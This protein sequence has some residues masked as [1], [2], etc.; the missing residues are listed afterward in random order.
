MSSTRVSSS[1]VHKVNLGDY[2]KYWGWLRSNS[3]CLLCIR[4]SPEHI[5]ACGHSIC[6][7]CVQIYGRLSLTAEEE[8]IVPDCILC[9]ASKDLTVQLKPPTAAP[10]V[11]SIDGG[12]PR[13]IIPLENLDILQRVLGPNLPL[14]HMIDLAVGCSSGGLIALS[15]FMLRMDNE[16][17]KSLFKTLAKK[18]FSPSLRKRFFHSWV[19]DSF[20]DVQPLEEAL[21]NHYTPTQRMFDAPMSGVSAC[22]VAVTTTTI[23]DGDTF[24]FAN[25]NGTAPHRVESGD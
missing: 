1:E 14:C 10:R 22:K 5:L 25:Y 15:R 11:V 9:G 6:D 13:G 16:S 17:C 20:Y 21:K 8:Y 19:S 18:V 4:R 12:G 3:T 2:Q 23:K 24:I 7:Q